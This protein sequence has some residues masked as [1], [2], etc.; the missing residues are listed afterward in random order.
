MLA[1][2]EAERA[3]NEARLPRRDEAYLGV[4]VDDLVTREHREPY[5][6]FTSAAEHRLLLRTDN[7]D[8]RLASLGHGLGLITDDQMERVR[9]RWDLVMREERRL[10]SVSVTVSGPSGEPRAMRA[11]DWLARPEGSYARLD[12][13]GVEASLPHALWPAL[14]VRVRYRGYIERQER[15]A[16]AA[17]TLDA[18]TLDA[19]F[20][21]QELNGVSREAIEKLRCWQPRTL[22]MAS[23]IAGV[24]PSDVAVLLVHARRSGVRLPAL[25]GAA[26]TGW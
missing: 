17:A 10:S 6:M 24:T 2:G 7:A 19:S 1:G 16:A 4:L 22:G 23:R 18:V 13:L 20:W 26:K 11:L 15:T 3:R 25:D 9:A 12:A 5:R 21:T 14:E 8:E